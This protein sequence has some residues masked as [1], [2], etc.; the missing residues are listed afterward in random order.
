MVLD[1]GRQSDQTAN[2]EVALGHNKQTARLTTR[3]L[4][5]L[6]QILRSEVTFDETS[7]LVSA[8]EESL[9]IAEQENDDEGE[10]SEDEWWILESGE[11]SWGRKPDSVVVKSS[12]KNEF[13]LKLR[14]AANKVLL[15]ISR[16]KSCCGERLW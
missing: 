12:R 4:S 3:Y 15:D 5:L 9:G 11:I 14:I 2:V 1:A 6:E 13:L 7:S 10:E 16:R 8:V